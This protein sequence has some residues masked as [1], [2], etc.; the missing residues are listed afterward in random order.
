MAIPAQDVHGTP[1]AVG[2]PRVLLY[3]TVKELIGDDA[4]SVTLADGHMMIV[5]P[6]TQV[7]VIDDAT[8]V[9]DLIAAAI[10]AAIPTGTI[11]LWSGSV[12]SIPAGW[13]LCDGTNGTVDLHDRFVVGAGGSYAVGATGGAAQV[14]PAGTVSTPTFAGN[15]AAPTSVENGAIDPISV[16]L[17]PYVPS[18]TISS[19][20]FTGAS[21]ENRPPFFALC[22]IQKVTAQPPAGPDQT[23]GI[24]QAPRQRLVRIGPRNRKGPPILARRP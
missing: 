18:G 3:A 5:N 22:Y 23:D 9:H 11:V 20:A 15:Q 7:E 2:Q 6:S 12:A 13:S 16:V 1:L 8:S 17:D 24:V 19:P 10:A 21:S 4:I 14:T